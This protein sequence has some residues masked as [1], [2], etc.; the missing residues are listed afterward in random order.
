MKMRYPGLESHSLPLAFAALKLVLHASAIARFGYFRDKLYYIACSKHLAWGY[1]DQPPLS[2]ALLALQRKLLG[3]SLPAL[4]LL[5]AL[6]GATTV[7][8]TGLLA[9]A[10]GGGRFAQ[11]LACLAVVL[12]PVHLVTDH[13]YSM[14]TF[15]TLFWTL[16]SLLLWRALE[17][18]TDPGRHHELPLWHAVR[19]RRADLR[20]PRT[21]PSGRRGLA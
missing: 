16:A 5:P 6:A 14:N 10:F 18:G 3:D 20:Q 11:A 4:R 12:A 15:D 1:V 2:I 9:R 8:L 21:A 7:L 19:E 13:F 17:K